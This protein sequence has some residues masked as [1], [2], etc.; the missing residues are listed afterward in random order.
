MSIDP[1]DNFHAFTGK[2]VLQKCDSDMKTG[3]TSAEAA[4]RLE[5]Y[6]PNEL[7]KEDPPTL[8]ERIKE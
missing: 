5:K 6:G 8:L 7:D 3:L 4:I 1:N 2:T